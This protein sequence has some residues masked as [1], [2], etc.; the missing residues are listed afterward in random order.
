MARYKI[1]LDDATGLPVFDDGSQPR[2]LGALRPYRACALPLFSNK[3]DV[4]PESRWSECSLKSW[5]APV[6]N[7]GA[8]GSCVGQGSATAFTY[9][10]RLSGQPYH[11][12]S[13]T[14]IYAR[15]NGGRDVGAVVSDGLECLKNYGVALM[16]QFG[17]DKIYEAQITPQIARTARRFRV[18]EAYKISTW[19]QMGTALL[20][21]MPCVS[22]IGIGRNFNDLD[23]DGIAPLPDFLIGGHCMAHIGL[24]QVAGKWYIQTQNSWSAGWGK[25]GFCLLQRG[26]WDGRYGFPFDAFAI[27]SPFDDP[28]DSSNDPPFVTS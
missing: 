28:D 17:Q 16:S 24:V 23:S 5:N 13:P 27:S 18:V 10:W 25:G 2:L 3:F 6:W 19:D 20:K 26:A 22:G 12:F 21:G 9:S 11:E 7:Q 1:E 4:I 14:S 15:I 8:F